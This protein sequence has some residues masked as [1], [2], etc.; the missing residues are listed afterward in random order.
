MF[1]IALLYHQPFNELK[2]WK[3]PMRVAL[4]LCTIFKEMLD[5]ATY[6]MHV[7]AACVLHAHIRFACMAT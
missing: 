1:G 2:Y 4:V 7:C 5:L 6:L 3:L